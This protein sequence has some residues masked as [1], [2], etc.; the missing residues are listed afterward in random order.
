MALSTEG[1]EPRMTD[2]ML[3]WLV[4]LCLSGSWSTTAYLAYIDHISSESG[5]R[6]GDAVA[7]IGLI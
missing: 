3:C 1:R 5:G 4:H 2:N 6:V 7:L